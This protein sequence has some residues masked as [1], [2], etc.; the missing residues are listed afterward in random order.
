MC[1]AAIAYSNA[2]DLAEVTA[3][4]EENGIPTSI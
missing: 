2:L 4:F 1:A 3:F